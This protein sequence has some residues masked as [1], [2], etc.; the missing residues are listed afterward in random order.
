VTRPL[1]I[2]MALNEGCARA[3]IA[4]AALDRRKRPELANVGY[5]DLSAS[6]MLGRQSIAARLI[7]RFESRH[8]L[9]AVSTY[10]VPARSRNMAAFWRVPS[11]RAGPGRCR[12]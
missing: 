11:R 12:R 4:A 1:A 7:F 10:A 8:P 2:V 5:A 3:A 9:A 6:S